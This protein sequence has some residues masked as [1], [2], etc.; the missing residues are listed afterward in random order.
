MPAGCDAPAH[1][2]GDGFDFA[3]PCRR[4]ASRSTG[5]GSSIKESM[6]GPALVASRPGSGHCGRRRRQHAS[7]K[8]NAGQ[9]GVAS[10]RTP[11][12]AQGS[13]LGL[14]SAS[15][16]RAGTGGEARTL[17]GTAFAL[18]NFAPPGVNRAHVREHGNLRPRPTVTGPGARAA[19]PSRDDAAGFETDHL[20]HRLICNVLS[21]HRL[22][23]RATG[24]VG[25]GHDTIFPLR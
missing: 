22:D 23:S 9:S 14:A 10:A 6:R 11:R 19:P 3:G 12:S 16:S 13:F 1:S 21:R 17:L 2:L 5:A 7:L 25:D 8:K 24:H 15:G 20:G 18:P 4:R